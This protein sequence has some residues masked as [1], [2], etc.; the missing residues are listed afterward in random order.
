[1]LL[2]SSDAKRFFEDLRYVVLDE[3]HSLVTSKRGHLLALGL[4]RLRRYVPDLQMV[5]LSATVAE[6]DELRRWLVGQNPPGD[7]AS[8]ITVE[9]GAKPHIAILIP[10]SGCHGP[11][12]PRICHPG[13]LRGD[14]KASDDAALRQ[15]A[16]PG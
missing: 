14:Q 6:P 1:M 4:A 15:H 11:G 8:L 13:S 2:A 3:L 7:M 10:M 9:G 16:Q 5:G 12:T